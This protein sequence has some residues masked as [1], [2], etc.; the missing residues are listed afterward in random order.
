[1]STAITEGTVSDI[2][3][4]TINDRNITWFTLTIQHFPIPGEPDR[5]TLLLSEVREPALMSDIAQ[6]DRLRLYG[7]LEQFSQGEENR[8][9][10]IVSEIE[11]LNVRQQQ[12]QREEQG[13][14]FT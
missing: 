14:L 5:K 8:I 10:I 6:G 9:K 4:K 11:R 7:N 12:P 1:M 2:R 13:V 3:S